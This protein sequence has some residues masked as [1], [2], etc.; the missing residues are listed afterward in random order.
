MGHSLQ[1][2][3]V[4]PGIHDATVFLILL[5]EDKQFQALPPIP[6]GGVNSVPS[7]GMSVRK[8]RLWFYLGIG[9]LQM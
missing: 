5:D 7:K 8:L 6:C 1:N 2:P 4:S 3:S 9:S